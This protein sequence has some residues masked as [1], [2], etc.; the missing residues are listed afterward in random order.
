MRIGINLY[1][2]QPHVGGIGNYVLS[3]LRAWPEYETVDTLIPFTFDVNDKLLSELP[4][5]ARTHEIR[6]ETQEQILEHRDK[7][8]VYFCPF[9][10]LYP[11]PVNKPAVITLVDIQERFF[12]GFFT[13]E[14]IASRLHH[15]DGSLSMSDQVITISEF[16]RQSMIRVLKMAPDKL[17]VIPLCTDE[18]PTQTQRP[19]IP[20]GW[21][22]AFVFFPA[23]DWAHKNH[24]RLI[25]AIHL[26]KQRGLN[27][28][29]VLTGTKNNIYP[30]LEREIQ[31]QGLENKFCHLGRVTRSEMAWLFH[32]ARMLVFPSLFEGFGIPLVEAMQ[33]N[34]PI[35]CSDTSSLP[36]VGGLA[37]VYFDPYLPEEIAEVIQHVWEDEALRSKLIEIGQKRCMLFSEQKLVEKHHIAFHK[38]RSNYSP[39]TYQINRIADRWRNAFPRQKIPA[40]QLQRASVMLHEHSATGINGYQGE[41]S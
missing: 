8:D 25:A 12:P 28:R 34:L 33:C 16:S 27:I 17:D 2:L 38:A 41:H 3:L 5:Q 4:A 21:D 36:E 24:K 37:A 19:A 20:E 7:F 22:H 26:L 18:L 23:N 10:A 40:Q 35:A 29:C 32:H 30:S 39:M 14:V 11:R 15:Y 31:S 9:G 1:M 13:Q 6:L